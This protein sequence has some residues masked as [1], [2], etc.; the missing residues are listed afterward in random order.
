MGMARKNG[1]MVPFLKVYMKMGIKQVMVSFILKMEAG[2]LYL[3][4]F[5]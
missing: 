5:Y 3:I 2:K 4:S 1:E